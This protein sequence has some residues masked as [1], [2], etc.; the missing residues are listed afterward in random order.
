[1]GILF[2]SDISH[3]QAEI[4]SSDR[5]DL[6]KALEAGQIVSLPSL[7]F[8]LLEFEQKF[9]SSC[10][11]NGSR[12]NISLDGDSVRGAAGNPFEL[13]ELARLMAR[14]GAHANQL[15]ETLFPHYAEHVRVART[16]YR[17]ARV[18][19][20][21]STWRKDDSRLH[22]DAFPSR[23]IG[24]ERILRV[25]TNINPHGEPRVWEV[26]E[27]FADAARRFLPQIRRP[28]PGS[29]RMLAALGVTKGRRSE[30][31]HI[32]LRLHDSMKAD[33]EYQRCATHQ[34]IEFPPGAT[35][36]C[37]SDQVLHAALDGQYL[38]EQTLYLPVAAQQYPEFSPLRTLER[39]RQRHL[40]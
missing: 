3:W 8:A 28:L 14:F 1:M 38:L 6:V 24:G 29:A 7:S 22:V 20:R 18:D 39:L 11:L 40:S 25:F 19:H 4:D 13:Q 37:F 31:D 23:P 17:P 12:K 10:W 5:A 35:W 26:G 27:P 33:P 30:Y 32:M 36:I 34:R 9:L 21:N 16:S 2:T 15:I